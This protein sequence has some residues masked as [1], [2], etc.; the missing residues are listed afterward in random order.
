VHILELNWVEDRELAF[1]YRTSEWQVADSI[2]P[3]VFM[4]KSIYDR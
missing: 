1:G 3:H 2:T 4:L